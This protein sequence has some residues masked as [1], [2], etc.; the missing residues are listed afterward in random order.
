MPW[1]QSKTRSLP[2]AFLS[3][4]QRDMERLIK[5][6]QY[7]DGA[8]VSYYLM[9]LSRKVAKQMQCISR[10]VFQQNPSFMKIK[11]EALGQGRFFSLSDS[12]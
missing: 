4:S 12:T 9:K 5:L 3:A 8:T 11:R 7:L 10:S 1:H 6:S 2:E